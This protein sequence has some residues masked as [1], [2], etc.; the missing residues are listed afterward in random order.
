MKDTSSLHNETKSSGLKANR[1]YETPRLVQLG[2]I[3]AV[4]LGGSGA[5]GDIGTPGG[6]RPK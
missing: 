5:N 2:V 4:T 3:R 1:P 6:K